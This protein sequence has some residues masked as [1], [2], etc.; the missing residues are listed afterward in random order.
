MKLKPFFVLFFFSTLVSSRVFSRDADP[1][2]RQI[3]WQEPI[4]TVFNEQQKFKSLMFENAAFNEHN[5]PYFAENI[6]LSGHPQTI[7]VQLVNARYEPFKEISLLPAEQ[8]I[9]TEATVHSQISYRKKIPYANITIIPFRKNATTGLTERLV[10]FDVTIAPGNNSVQQ[11]N[12]RS[13]S[14]SSVLSGGE[15]YKIGVT[16]EGIYKLGYQFL[17]NMGID[18]DH[19]DPRNIKVYGNGGG[20]LP[21]A[22]DVPRQDD[23]QQNAIFV[24]GENDGHFDDNDYI[25]FYGQSAVRWT[26]NNTDKQ[27]HH[28]L[29][30]YSD[31]TFYFINA[32]PGLAARRIQV[33]DSTTSTPTHIVTDFDDYTFHEAELSCLIKSGREWYG[34]QFDV[35]NNT[36]FFDFSF[37][38][39]STGEAVHI[40]ADAVGRSTNS[41]CA[42]TVYANGQNISTM[43]FGSMATVPYWSNYAYESAVADSFT[44]ATPV[45]ST[46]LQF[47]ANDNS[48]VGW[49]NYI[50]LNARRR[51]SF[52]GAGNQLSFRDTKSA[53]SGNVA[54]YIVS[55]QGLNIQVWDVTDPL[56]V[57]NQRF[58]TNGLNTTFT[59]PSDQLHQFIAFNGNSFLT[60][61]ALGKVENQNLHG[62][63]QTQM[64]ILTHP[65]F[66]A[67]ANQL[68]DFHRTHDHLSVMVVTNEQVYNEFSSGAPDVSAIRDFMKMFY[69][70]STSTL[71]L[72]KYLLLM[73]DASYDNKS[74]SS[75]NT[76]FILS[77][78]SKESLV[79][80]SSYISDDFFTLLDDNEG[81]WDPGD[82]DMP[83]IAVGRLPVK[84][85]AEAAAVVKKIITYGSS[86]PASANVNQCQD[87]SGSVFGDWRNNV[88]FVADD[89]D[90]N[91]HFNNTES[92]A[93]YVKQHY[94]VYNIDK[95]YL[96]AYKQETTPGGQRYP[97][98]RAAIVNRVQ[99]G[100]LLMTYVGHGGEVG[101][102]HERVLEV[103]DIN[104]WSNK[105][106]AAVLTA[107]CEFSRVDDPGRT[108]AGELV[109]LN[110]R[111]GGIALFS[112]SRLAL[113]G[114]NQ[115]LASKFFE[116]CFEPVNGKMPTMGEVFEQTKIDGNSLNTRNFLLLGDPALPL[117]YPKWNVKTNSI[118]AVPVDASPDTLT[119]LSKI[120]ISGEVQD[121]NGQKLTHYNGVIYP[122]VYDKAVTYHT[123]GNDAGEID[124]D[125]PAPFVMQKNVLY[126]GKASV[127][128][129][130]FK[131]TFVV[132]KDISFQYGF[133][134]LSYYAANGSEDANGYYENIVIGGV[135]ASV[136][137]DN[138][139]PD[140]RLFMNDDKFVFGG[141]T[142]QNP[143]LYATVR[144]S[145]GINTI[146]N[147][148]GHDITAQLDN[149][150][151]KLFILNDYYQADLDNY[152]KGSVKYKL[153]DL[154][155][156][157]HS[158]KFKVWD[159]FNNSGEAYTEFVVA[160]SATL[161]L[162]HVLNYPNPFS[163][164]TNFMFEYNCSCTSMEVMIQIFTVSG[165][166]VKTIDQHIY[167]NGYRSNSIE[168]DG[169]DDYG[170]KI[171]RGVYVYKLKVKVTDEKYAEKFEKLVILK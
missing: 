103:D 169:L 52:A 71:D 149:E 88:S 164:H 65:N 100:T 118:N 119:A 144:D 152:Q 27:F 113:A 151:N 134:R 91:T 139:G 140:V 72:P 24:S 29:N 128:N 10:S 108:S 16:Q 22:N 45:I 38:N 148:I 102:A 77:Y 59:L 147:G 83:D 35:V 30:L 67:A 112:T 94:P 73:G 55:S 37:P 157:N 117:A 146:G 132:P 79:W 78:E 96:D 90:G 141:L 43:N 163:T 14:H 133:G 56:N 23:L 160:G 114:S 8:A 107:T 161:A 95:I 21:Y 66:L 41:S 15:W 99:R 57:M 162:D 61:R 68:A 155:E 159:V 7:A 92:L 166:L 93:N 86:D 82:N 26:Y 47:S 63:P 76:N 49:L 28:Q 19:I 17:K 64:I 20:M 127:K 46:S 138:K 11:N 111:G 153:S 130:E 168:W 58:S 84:T 32:D 6:P 98:A 143:Y 80:I 31:S 135:N 125:Y 121:R 42:F 126:R 1:L 122:T 74:R 131:F 81:Q 170:D 110:P 48:A 167:T 34:E 54:Q 5:V 171:G 116:H 25:L 44:S 89:Q 165:K 69:D 12:A 2:H 9:G 104:N 51:I 124:S 101:W 18:V 40:K 36:K 150:N 120:S 156:G 75:A 97:D 129:G 136:A 123:L 4:E 115:V 53:G 145:N 87:E 106:L 85:P 158:L 33:Q 154:G 142:D 62:L 50:E 105:N 60:A 70:R 137:M 3:K 109:L 13:Y 39:L